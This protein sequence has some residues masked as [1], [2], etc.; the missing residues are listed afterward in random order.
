MP[1]KPTITAYG[2]SFAIQTGCGLNE[3][4]T[5]GEI[6]TSSLN[7][8]LQTDL[9]EYTNFEQ[10]IKDYILAKLGHPIVRVELSD[11]QVKTC[12][13]EAVNLLNYHAPSWTTQ[14][15]TFEA[16]AGIN[17]YEIPTYIIDNLTYVVYK[18]TLLSIQSQAGTLEFDFF[19]KYF[20]DNFLFQ[21]FEIATFYQL[22]QHLEIIRKTLGMEGSFDVI[23]GQFLQIY[24]APAVTPEEVILEYRALD[25]RTMHPYYHNFIQRYATACAKENLGNIRSKY[26]MLP[27]PGGGAKLNGELLLQEG[28][29]E[30]EK[31]EE[32]LIWDIGE[33]PVW[34]AF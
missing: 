34:T 11:F 29:R 16:T 32:N 14:Y 31:L 25:S 5:R 22:Q 12:I 4:E 13:D 21:D 20:Q 26:V 24:P 18:K 6:T 7:K 23:N 27:S 33:P 1:A 19:I 9:I 10:P 17:L 28:I 8:K 30:K 2:N 15:A 3:A